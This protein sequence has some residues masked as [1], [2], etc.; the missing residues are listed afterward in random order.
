MLISTR[1]EVC[2]PRQTAADKLLSQPRRL[3]FQ[4]HWLGPGDRAFGKQ[5][6]RPSV[7]LAGVYSGEQCAERTLA[8][9]VSNIFQMA[10]V[11][12]GETWVTDGLTELGP[13]CG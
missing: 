8:S 10:S 13:Q 4:S 5:S 12:Y 9:L 2:G 3:A 1:K 6:S 7:S 11:G